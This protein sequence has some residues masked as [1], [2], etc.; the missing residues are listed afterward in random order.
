VEVAVPGIGTLRIGN[1]EG[2]IESVTFEDG[3]LQ[4]FAVFAE[5]LV[6]DMKGEARIV[7][8]DGKLVW[9]GTSFHDWGRK[10]VQSR[11]QVTFDIKAPVAAGGRV[12]YS[13]S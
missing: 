7:G 8:T 12:P 2:D 1:L 10:G 4:V 13:D 11:W 5:N 6:G 3:N 9:L